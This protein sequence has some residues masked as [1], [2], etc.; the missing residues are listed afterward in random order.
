MSR[1]TCLYILTATLRRGGGG[2]QLLTYC[3]QTLVN[4]RSSPDVVGGGGGG[5]EKMLL[6][7]VEP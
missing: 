6:A 7:R 1:H 5:G 3:L 2:K 4:P